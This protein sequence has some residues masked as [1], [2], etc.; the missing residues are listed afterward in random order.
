M[1]VINPLPY[2]QGSNFSN[3]DHDFPV[4]EATDADNLLEQFEEITPDLNDDDQ[5]TSNGKTSNIFKAVQNHFAASAAAASNN[6]SGC[7][8]L[9][10]IGDYYFSTLENIFSSKLSLLISVPSQ[11]IKDAIP[12]EIIERIKASSQKSRTIAIIEPVNNKPDSKAQ[13]ASS[14]SVASSNIQV[15][16]GNMINKPSIIS[17][18]HVIQPASAPAAARHTRFAEAAN[19]LHKTKTLR[20]IS[21]ASSAASSASAASPQQVQIS[22]DHDYCSSSSKMKRNRP[23]LTA[24]TASRPL[25][26]LQ[27]TSVSKPSSIVVSSPMTSKSIVRVSPPVSA[28]AASTNVT[29]SVITMPIAVEVSAAASNAM[30]SSPLSSPARKD[31]GLESGEASDTSESQHATSASSLDLYSKVPNYLTSVSVQNADSRS[32]APAEEDAKSYDRLGLNKSL[33]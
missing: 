1:L 10:R 7:R 11:R 31:S 27:P 13:T 2:N 4:L 24:S 30:A 25:I 15:Q 6:N 20:L 17:K 29:E 23:L 16:V 26:R 18:S 9:P 14:N 12:R 22:L 32:V 21:T 33:T 28:S 19:S 3:S 8:R 5:H